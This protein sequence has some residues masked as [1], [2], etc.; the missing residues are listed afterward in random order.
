MLEYNKYINICLKKKKKE[1]KTQLW[2]WHFN[3]LHE[4][5]SNQQCVAFTTNDKKHSA[6]YTF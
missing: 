1:V 2:C 4:Y 3:V 6:E 5:D